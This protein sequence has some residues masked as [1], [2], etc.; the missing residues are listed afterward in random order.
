MG[1]KELVE[2]AE[3]FRN[4]EPGPLTVG[5][6]QEQYAVE[7]ILAERSRKTGKEFLVKW[8]GYKDSSWILEADVP[9]EIR[10]LLWKAGSEMK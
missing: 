8:I 4:G 1:S 7:A 10:A 3:R 2:V 9:V 5:V 6:G